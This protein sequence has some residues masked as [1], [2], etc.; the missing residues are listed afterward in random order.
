MPNMTVEPGLRPLIM[1]EHAAFRGDPQTRSKLLALVRAKKAPLRTERRSTISRK[2]PLPSNIRPYVGPQ[3][4]EPCINNALFYLLEPC[5]HRVMTIL[6]EHCARNCHRPA[7]QAANLRNRDLPFFCSNCFT[8]HVIDKLVKEEA[9]RGHKNG[10]VKPS[11]ACDPEDWTEEQE[12]RAEEMMA[13]CIAETQ[14]AEGHL[15][16]PCK[17]VWGE[18]AGIEVDIVEDPNHEH[19]VYID[20]PPPARPITASRSR[21]PRPMKRTVSSRAKVSNRRRTG[22]PVPRW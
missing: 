22:L 18:T 20:S 17:P 2:V 11:F 16:K 10:L 12:L 15:G 7:S 6:P 9:G 5:G 13:Y 8:D 21:L 3:T 19:W 14:K 4:I 1:P